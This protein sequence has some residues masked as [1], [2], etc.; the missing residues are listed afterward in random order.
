MWNFFIDNSRFTYLLIFVLICFGTFSIFSIS[1]ES[2][3]EVQIPVGIVTTVL[4]GAPAVDIENLITNE[5]ERGLSGS[6]EN[7]KK[8]TSTSKESVSS[9]TVEF[10]AEADIDESISELKDKVDT[11]VNR[12]PDEAERP[13]VT[14]INFVDQPIM[15]IAVSGDKTPEEFSYLAD[16]LIDEIEAV[17]G[18]SKVEKSGV[19]DREIT[20]LVDQAALLRF[21][22]TINDVLLGIRSAN[23]TFPVGQIVSDNVS[24]NIIFSGKADT[25]ESI[26]R[27]PV[28]LR[29]DQPVLVQDVAQVVI[30]LAPA[31]TYSRLS[32]DG[33]LSESS[34]ILSIFKERG[35]DITV[36]T[37][38]VKN[39]LSALQGN[40]LTD[41]SVYYVYN[42]GDDI[43]RD[44]S[45]LT[46]SGLQT[47]VIVILILIVAIG[48]RE[49]LI[50]GL[51]IPLTFTIGFI[52]L[53]YSNNTLNFISLFALILGIGVLVDSGIVV[54]EGIN[55]RMRNN[56][57]MDK[58]DAARETV[59][60]F[61][62]P[63]VSGTFTTVA[64]FVGLLVVG[65]VTGQ[66]ISSIPFTLIFIMLA[67]LI[68]ALGFL[69][70]I[71]AKLLKN[72]TISQTEESQT[73]L[74][75]KVENW[76]RDVLTNIIYSAKLKKR[77]LILIV[78]GLITAIAL[79]PAGFVKVVFFAQ[80]DVDD[81][82]VEIELSEGSIKESTD[83]AVRKVEEHLYKYNDVIEAFSTTVGSGSMFGTNGANTRFANI[84]ISLREDRTV[85]S[86][87][88][89]ET[90]RSDLSDIR[91]VKVT[92]SQPSDGPPTG[93]PIGVKLFGDDIKTLTETANLIAQKLVEIE[94]TT[95]IKTD[96]DTNT[97]EIQF[98]VD[99]EK[100]KLYGFNP[101]VISETL[102]SAV[103]GTEATSIT[104][105]DSDTEVIVRLNL[106]N[107]PNID[108]EFA[109]WTNVNTLQNIELTTQ[110]GERIALSALSEIVLHES[111]SVI[112]HEDEKRVMTVGADITPTGN[113]LEINNELK[114]QI[115]E[116]IQ[117]PSGV[118]YTLG[119]ETEES[120][121][122]FI[123]MLYALLIG[124][125]LMIA[126]LVLQFDSY[127]HAFYVIS[128][129]P[130]SLIGILYGLAITGSAL[131]FP[132]I[133]GF[134]ALTGIIVNNSILLIDMMNKMRL[135]NPD[136][137]IYEVVI[138]SSVNRLRPIILT[139][140]S[141]VMGMTP[142]L[143]SDEIWIPLATAI[144][145]GLIFSV[146]ITLVLIPVI[147]SKWPGQVNSKF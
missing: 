48:W 119:G 145:F 97:T 37:E 18:V 3:P 34:L 95:N 87:N 11:L 10:S 139:S 75:L 92:V 9:I 137:S 51:S 84:Q 49:G 54:V 131:S 113:V 68:V 15:T 20:V 111:S 130:F 50:A 79:I 121:Q 116:N 99:Q 132:S 126:I 67:S 134:I 81:I 106:T 136:K 76:Y 117:L 36:M 59:N 98:I 46:T 17:K 142:L 23:N 77:F 72:K 24:Y 144:I 93:S 74:S 25:A 32:T 115:A 112:K 38:E 88:F 89:I 47:V 96:S 22:L 103:H 133:L 52:G 56:P 108:P 39:K 44:L 26:K 90:L 123:E 35:N 70:L 45:N 30:G 5:L 100:A 94:G 16:N 120:N 31:N 80:S 102:R 147:Y 57:S 2:A 19:R 4:P 69:P 71:T 127:R 78:V 86:S 138:E 13:T 21:N 143:F 146:I 104:S 61:S 43:E 33:E 29:G 62:A 40:L 66:F 55:K 64:M 53:Y 107:D 27:I 135:S 83:I 122:A 60:E 118:T 124:I 14:E 7:V 110:S 8:I 12:L 63:L 6:L 1:R 125:V 109:N 141:T 41:M 128:I 58:I 101:Q 65:G 42:A 91:D 114:K 85:T 28:A 82:F 105:L 129:L 140:A 73:R